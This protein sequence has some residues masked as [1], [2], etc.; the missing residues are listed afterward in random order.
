MSLT[1]SDYYILEDDHTLLVQELW[2]RINPANWP[3]SIDELPAGSALVGGA[4]RDALLNILQPKPD[5]DLVISSQAV[6]LAQ[7]FSDRLGGTCVVL[8]KERDIARL[9]IDGWTIDF[10][11]QIGKNLE[12]DL[13]RRDF[14]INAIA[15]TLCSNPKIVDPFGGIKDLSNKTLVAISE[16]NLIEDPLRMLRGCRL[17]SQLNFSLDKETTDFLLTHC[18]LLPQVSPER[19][20]NEIQKLVEGNWADNVLPILLQI[21]LMNPWRDPNQSCL[22]QSVYLRDAKNFNSHE[23]AIAL[24]LV[25][26]AGLLSDQGLIQLCFSKKEIHR[27]QILRKWQKMNDGNAFKS[28]TESERFQLHIELENYLPALIIHIPIDDQKIWL[29][30]WRDFSDPLFHPSSPLDGA[31]LKEILGVPE[32]PLLGEII[33]YLCKEKAFNRLH[34]RDE[35]VELARNLWKQKQPLM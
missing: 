22:N 25:R 7:E 2:G 14:R 27:C 26:L 15:M 10:A 35:A 1:L 20:K 33:K 23:L 11:K 32:G 5:L 12:E 29:R 31:A 28:L 34:S 9:V 8:D 19:I 24:P 21:G 3:F 30:R 16:E 13:R 4:V 6:K 18:N 17:M